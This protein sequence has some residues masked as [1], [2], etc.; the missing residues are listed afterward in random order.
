[1]TISYIVEVDWTNTGTWVDI[2]QWALGETIQYGKHD[3]GDTSYYLIGSA[4]IRLNNFDGRFHNRNTGSP[5]YPNILPARPVRVRAYDGT[6][7]YDIFNGYLREIDPAGNQAKLVNM[8]CDGILGYYKESD[9]DSGF[10]QNKLTS[11]IVTAYLTAVGVPVAQQNVDTGQTTIQYAYLSRKLGKALNDVAAAEQG[12]IYG[13]RGGKIRFESR[14][15]RLQPAQQTVSWALTADK[16][17]DA[18][19]P[20]G[21]ETVINEWRVKTYPV[22]I[23][24]STT[25]WSLQDVVKIGAG[26]TK[27]LWGSYTDPA[28][29]NSCGGTSVSTAPVAGTDYTANSAS[30]GTGTDTTSD[31]SITVTP[32][33][34]KVKNEVTNNGSASTYLLTLITNGQPVVAHDVEVRQIDSTSQN[35]YG[36]RVRKLAPKVLQDA[37]LAESIGRFNLAITKDP[38]GPVWAK[39]LVS[40]N[41]PTVFTAEISD[42][43][44]VTDSVHYLSGDEFYIEGMSY[45]LKPGGGSMAKLYLSPADT[46]GG[47]FVVGYAEVG[48][49]TRLAY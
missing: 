38:T 35:A 17:L 32:F 44:S 36:P 9:V 28:S 24:S 33:G 19:A 18:K 7:Y 30:D 6:T 37:E 34:D 4:T 22:E 12:R 16:I 49:S 26:E 15:Y 11:E 13:E 43:V 8:Y 10:E 25:L 42:R 41:F 45:E 48:T 47:W 14:H 27:T 3:G 5:Y 39:L 31:I 2:S 1:M 21:W 46:T 40:N 29:G 23:K 20:L